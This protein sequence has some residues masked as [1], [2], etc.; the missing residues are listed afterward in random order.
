LYRFFLT[1][2]KAS[3]A[4]IAKMAEVKFMTFSEIAAWSRTLNWDV[5]NLK[6]EKKPFIMNF[7]LI[8]PNFLHSRFRIHDGVVTMIVRNAYFRL[9]TS[10]MDASRENAL[11]LHGPRG[12]GKSYLLYMFAAELAIRQR[13]DLANIRVTYINDCGAWISERHNYFLIELIATFSSDETLHL[14]SRAEVIRDTYEEFSRQNLILQLVSDVLAFVIKQGLRWFI[15]FDQLNAFHTGRPLSITAELAWSILKNLASCR[16][17]Q[18]SVLGSASANNE[19]IPI[20]FASWESHSV[21]LVPYSYEESEFE[22]WCQNSKLKPSDDM[23]RE[24]RHYTG[25]IPL[26]LDFF[27]R[28]NE[29]VLSDKLHAY[30]SARLEQLILSHRKFCN[31][32]TQHDVQ[33]LK[34]CIGRLALRLSPPDHLC[35]MDRQLLVIDEDQRAPGKRL[36][37]LFPLARSAV[38]SYHSDIIQESLK[39]VAEIVFEAQSNYPNDVKGRVV[40]NYII[41]SLEEKRHYNFVGQKPTDFQFQGKI[42]EIVYFDGDSLPIKS[43]ISNYLCSLIIPTSSRYPGMD[44]FIWNPAAEKKM[45][46]AVQVTAQKSLK[47]HMKSCKFMWIDWGRFLQIPKGS[48]HTLWI[49][50]KECIEADLAVK[51]SLNYYVLAFDA[52]EDLCPIIQKFKRAQKVSMSR[53]KADMAAD[54]S[55]TDS[56]DEVTRESGNET[57]AI[58]LV[59]GRYFLAACNSNVPQGILKFNFS[60]I[61]CVS[62]IIA[63][64]LRSRSHLSPHYC[65]VPSHSFVADFVSLM[66]SDSPLC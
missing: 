10:A 66:F 50:P 23:I 20:E 42:E 58:P 33:N 31:S 32:L 44:F 61:S 45:L 38:L 49:A 19:A 40:E 29:T 63:F 52:L 16:S 56:Q 11:Y 9:K 28:I 18:V 35:A 64:L 26:E 39:N 3:P 27:N 54:D 36:V 37:A 48:I 12:V 62:I 59:A 30:K 43:T 24:V 25:G 1:F 8:S 22:L 51:N 47:D 13:T 60:V 65:Q 2:A 17:L 55:S 53:K 15:I 57:C 34:D 7:P 14:V 46:L 5:S 4:D 21:D 41:A 6:Q